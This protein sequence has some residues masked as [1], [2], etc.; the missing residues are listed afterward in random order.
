MGL[1]GSAEFH[2]ETISNFSAVVFS[3]AQMCQN[4]HMEKENSSLGVVVICR[5]DQM[6][7][8]WRN[9]TNF[10]GVEIMDVI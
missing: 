6:K 2:N 10:E 5:C 9:L 7:V 8:E 4:V 3:T 1:L